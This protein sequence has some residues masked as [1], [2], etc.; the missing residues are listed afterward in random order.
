MYKIEA[1]FADEISGLPILKMLNNRE[2]CTVVPKLKF[3]RN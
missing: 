3:V 2:Q 1:P